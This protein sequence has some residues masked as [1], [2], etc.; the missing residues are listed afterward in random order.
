MLTKTEIKKIL[1]DVCLKTEYET[2]QANR[3]RKDAIELLFNY[4][5][6]LNVKD[7]GNKSLESAYRHGHQKTIM[8]EDV[9]DAILA[10]REPLS[11]KWGFMATYAEI[12]AA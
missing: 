3:I 9:R 6:N 4:A 5:Q 11:I 7:I 12:G 1:K 2:I 8:L 10:N